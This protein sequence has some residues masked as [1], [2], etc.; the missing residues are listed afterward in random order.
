MIPQK[1]PFNIPFTRTFSDIPDIGEVISEI[2]KKGY[3]ISPGGRAGTNRVI[4]KRHKKDTINTAI[5][6]ICNYF[7]CNLIYSL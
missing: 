3:I 6:D 4:P 2:S 5:P 7:I 1:N